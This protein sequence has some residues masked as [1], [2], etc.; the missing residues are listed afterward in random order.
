MNDLFKALA[1]PSRRKI[2]RLLK[3]G[4]MN[5]GE[6][7]AHFEIS[8]ASLNHHLNILKSGGLVDAEKKGQYM[9]YTLNTTVF[10]E[11]IEW[12]FEIRNESQQTPA[13]KKKRARKKNPKKGDK[14]ES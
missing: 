3:D 13:P 4:P 5:V 1:D 10:H 14:N 12:I 7:L 6:I 8:G 9:I 2:I 11:M